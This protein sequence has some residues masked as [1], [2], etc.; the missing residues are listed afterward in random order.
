MATAAVDLD[1]RLPAGRRGR[2]VVAA[3]VALALVLAGC[4]IVRGTISTVKALDRAGFSS[5][6]IQMH[7]QDGFV[8][9]VKK[10]T[11]D[12]DGAAVEAAGVV[13]R[14]LPLRIERLEVV[15]GNGFGGKGSFAAD[16]A[17]L[18]RRFGARDP[19]LDRGVQDSDLRTVAIV[20]GALVLAG[21]LV[22]AGIVVLVV[23]LVRRNRRKGP[24][25]GP[26]DPGYYAQPPPPGYGPQP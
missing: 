25:P 6:K 8:V 26:P 2:A 14:K 20:I 3:V 15:C 23:V 24:P 10:D 9:R 5:P 22:M 16:R 13:W 7:G 21:L 11:E 18:E 17:E 12:L 4:G 1:P 19:A